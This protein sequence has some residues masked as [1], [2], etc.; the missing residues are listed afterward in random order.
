VVQ[1]LTVAGV[2]PDGEGVEVV[3]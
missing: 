2:E 1:A 3:G